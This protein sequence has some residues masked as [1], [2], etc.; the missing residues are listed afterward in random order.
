LC[1]TLSNI[2]VNKQ[3]SEGITICIDLGQFFSNSKPCISFCVQG[4]GTVVAVKVLV[5][6]GCSCRLHGVPIVC[7]KRPLSLDRVSVGF[8]SVCDIVF[9]KTCVQFQV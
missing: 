3:Q 6:A 2:N 4:A 5:H 9:W 8:T 1:G 7:R